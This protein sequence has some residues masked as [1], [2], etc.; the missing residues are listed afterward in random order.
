MTKQAE[1]IM[2]QSIWYTKKWQIF[3]VLLTQAAKTICGSI[4]GGTDIKQTAW[5]CQKIN[6]T[7]KYEKKTWNNYLNN[8]TQENYNTYKIERTKVKEIVR[9]KKKD[10]GIRRTDGEKQP[11]KAKAA[12][13]NTKN[14]WGRITTRQNDTIK[15][16]EGILLKAEK[17]IMNKWKEYFNLLKESESRTLTTTLQESSEEEI[18]LEET[19]NAIKMTKNEK[20]AGHD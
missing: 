9:L 2:T 7:I 6:E 3:K 13:Q 19:I 18:T 1:N 17:E 15:S 16:K 10:E 20:A 11:G 5:W 8:K 14:S 4:K 12:L